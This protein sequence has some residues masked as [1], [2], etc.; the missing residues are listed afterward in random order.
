MR[1]VQERLMAYM[2]HISSGCRGFFLTC[3]TP[4]R[5]SIDPLNYK[6]ICRI[7]HPWMYIPGLGRWQP[8]FAN[9]NRYDRYQLEQLAPSP[10]PPLAQS[11]LHTLKHCICYPQLWNL[12][13]D[14]SSLFLV[15]ASSSSP[16]PAS[17][18]QSSTVNSAPWTNRSHR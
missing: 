5:R 13:L 11:K 16:R 18:N 1:Y 2:Q 10:S 9:C 4:E 15:F 3:K 7:E 6:T 12:L 14:F 8:F 17:Q